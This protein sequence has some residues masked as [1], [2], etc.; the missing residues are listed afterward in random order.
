MLN[1]EQ[2]EKVALFFYYTFLDELKAH[3][4]TTKTLQKIQSLKIGSFTDE[5]FLSAFIKE[6]DLFIKK[7]GATVNTTGLSYSSGHIDIPEGSNWGPW[8]EFRRLGNQREFLAVLYNVILKIPVHTLAASLGLPEGTI[9]FRIGR[10]LKFL[11]TVAEQGG[12]RA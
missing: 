6:T 12:I 2:V 4:A 5:E 10:G 3:A 11:G 9:R 7:Y 1:E 8:F